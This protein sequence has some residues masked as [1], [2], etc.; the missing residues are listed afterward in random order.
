MKTMLKARAWMPRIKIVGRTVRSERGISLI[1]VLMLMV[2]IL[3]IIGA[4]LFFSGIDLRVSG[5]YRAGTQAFYAADTGASVGFSQIQ[6]SVALSTAAFG[7]PPVNGVAYCSG[8][9]AQTGPW[10]NCNGKPL[11]NP[12]ATSV[13]VEA[14]L[15]SGSVYNS[16]RAGFFTYSY[17]ID[18]TGVG[19]LGATRQVQALATF[20]PVQ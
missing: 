11:M 3:A 9:I 1:V 17:Q 10:P 7:P 18:V 2:I 13:A 4:G 14:T 12:P 5:N 15:S 19:P 8:T 20:G 6:S 16:D